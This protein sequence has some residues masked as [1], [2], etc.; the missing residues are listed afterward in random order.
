MKRSDGPSLGLITVLL[1][2]AVALALMGAWTASSAQERAIRVDGRV[3]WIAGDKMM[4]LPEPTGL[5]VTID[6][7]RV[8]QDHY[9]T[10][11]QGT[12]VVVDGV[13]PIGTRRLIATSI[14]L[15]GDGEDRTSPTS[16]T[17]R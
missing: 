6:L 8:P 10:L 17:S 15:V 1:G 14:V 12:W 5:P 13:T 9:A 2:I 16:G 11:K 4:L 3:Q 7:A